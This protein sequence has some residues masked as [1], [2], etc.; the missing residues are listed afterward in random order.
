M[1]VKNGSND[2][3]RPRAHEVR[4]EA[5]SP[6]TPW[7]GAIG[8]ALGSVLQQQGVSNALRFDCTI[9]A[10]AWGLLTGAGALVLIALG[11]AISWRVFAAHAS[12]TNADSTRRFIASLSLL[13]SL[14]AFGF[15][16]LMTL[17]TFIVPPCPP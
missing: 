2:L 8:A 1:A 14:L 6:F 17:A 15:V 3:E 16:L 13:A 5:G 4:R 11:A 10:P 12:E 9:D 7:A